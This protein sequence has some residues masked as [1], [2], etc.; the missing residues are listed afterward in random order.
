MIE[1]PPEKQLSGL[2]S[3]KFR[4]TALD[5]GDRSVWTNLPSNRKPADQCTPKS[6][7]GED[8]ELTYLSERDKEMEKIVSHHNVCIKY[9][10]LL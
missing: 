2:G 4:T 9:P 1:L 6:K 3:R 10:W 8:N 7:I 5:L